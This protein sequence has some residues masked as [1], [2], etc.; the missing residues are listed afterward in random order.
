MRASTLLALSLSGCGF[1]VQAVPIGAPAP[2]RPESCDVRLEPI[3][4]AE[5]AQRFVQVGTLCVVAIDGS[6]LQEI[7]RSN[8]ALAAMRPHACSLGGEVL[9]ASGFCPLARNTGVEVGVYRGR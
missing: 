3:T 7:A 9:V 8:D 4:P 6:P 1:M 5:A 2:P